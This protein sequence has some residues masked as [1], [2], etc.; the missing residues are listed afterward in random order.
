ENETLACPQCG[1]ANSVKEV[2][3]GPDA[4]CMK[5]STSLVLD[6]PG[7]RTQDPGLLPTHV[8]DE[9]GRIDDEGLTKLVG[10]VLGDCTLTE[11]LGT[12]GMGAVYQGYHKTL[13]ID[14]AVKII[15]PS[16]LAS[17][18]ARDRFIREARATVALEHEN[19]MRIFNL[20]EEKG[21]LYIIMQ[22]LPGP[23]LSDIVKKREILPPPEAVLYTIQLLRALEYAHEK[24]ILHRDVKPENLMF[25]KDG[26][27]RLTD[28][29]LTRNLKG[30]GGIT[31]TGAALGTPLFMPVEQWDNE[32]VDRRADIYAAGV[33]LFHIAEPDPHATRVRAPHPPRRVLRQPAPLP[34]C[35]GQ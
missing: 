29:G 14:V 21:F 23:T 28:F 24:G 5:C 3:S 1:Y 31:Q 9:P 18:D 30:T 16:A 7:M 27:I 20:G 34:L 25:D 11:L 13:G 32:G 6:F 33:T 4:Q 17:P 2:G 22:H 15:K 26:R 12:G 19:I 8:A 10:H 35:R